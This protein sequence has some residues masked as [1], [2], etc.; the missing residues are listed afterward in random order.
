M[1]GDRE[2]TRRSRAIISHFGEVE[3]RPGFDL[4]GRTLLLPEPDRKILSLPKFSL[5]KLVHGR[6][7]KPPTVHLHRHESMSH[8]EL[9][10][11][12]AESLKFLQRDI[13]TLFDSH[14]SWML[15]SLSTDPSCRSVF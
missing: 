3:V 13:D 4:C 11:V 9:S 7:G 12:E 8:F 6:K 15:G 10:D 1:I 5:C 14:I 2:R